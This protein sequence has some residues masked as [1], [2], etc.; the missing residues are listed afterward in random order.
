M[1]KVFL[2]FYLTLSFLAFGQG[3]IDG[4]ILDDAGYP[5]PGVQVAL[6]KDADTIKKSQTDFYGNFVFKDLPSNDYEIRMSY[7]AMPDNKISNIYVEDIITK[8]LTINYPALCN[9][10]ERICPHNHTNQII[11]IVYGMASVKMEKK[12]QKGK[13]KLG[14]CIQMC[15]AWHCKIHNIDF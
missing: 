9:K 14:G 10:S 3:T 5:I 2:F 1:K 12:A 7:V 6:I 4:T 11:P 15:E 8:Y 13:I